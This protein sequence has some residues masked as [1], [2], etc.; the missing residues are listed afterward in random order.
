M[1]NTIKDIAKALNISP[2]TV[3]RALSDNK[4]ISDETKKKVKKM[5]K[6]LNYQKNTW[7]SALRTKETKMLGV[8]VPSLKNPF[9]AHAISGMQQVANQVGLRVVIC[10]SN[11]DPETEKAQLYTLQASGAEG[12]AVSITQNTK[13]LEHFKEVEEQGVPVL[14]FDRGVDGSGFHQVEANDF[15]SG[16]IATEHLI[17]KGCKN[18][19]HLAG[20][21]HL[22]NSRKRL[23]GYQA[24]LDEHGIPFKEELVIETGYETQNFSDEWID[25]ILQEKLKVDGIFAVSD[26]IAI[27]AMVKL[28]KKGIKVPQDIKIIGFGRDD[29]G[30]WVNPN[31]STVTQMPEKM[32]RETV[33]LFLEIKKTGLQNSKAHEIF[34]EAK[35]IERDSSR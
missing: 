1:S 19:V 34:T 14:F 32:G 8:I 30:E 27:T 24:A 4:N 6:K 15:E 26:P 28:Q 18:I 11:E 25:H 31:L 16:K 10:Q 23:E 13:S 29:V 17:N 20:P 21:K 35:L 22:K 33:N 3:S 5:A 12:I 9:F 2:S 7:A